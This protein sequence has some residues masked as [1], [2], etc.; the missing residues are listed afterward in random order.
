MGPFFFEAPERSQ[1]AVGEKGVPLKL[2]LAVRDEECSP[3][4]SVKVDLWSA[5]ADGLYSGIDEE[6]RQDDA[7]G[8]RL[9]G[10]QVTD[11]GGLVT[12]ETVIPAFYSERLPHMHFMIRYKN[13]SVSSQL[14]FPQA[15]VAEVVQLDPYAKRGSSPVDVQ[16]DVV[17]G[18]DVDV[19]KA[20]TLDV[21]KDRKNSTDRVSYSANFTAAIG[22]PGGA[23]LAYFEPEDGCS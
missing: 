14:Y 1:L 13:G 4:P 10:Y 8:N 20:L 18:G 21:R 9:R 7:S 6:G 19:L 22:L 17:L 15:V 2:T 11:A 23:K 5:D 12:F 3:V 16:S